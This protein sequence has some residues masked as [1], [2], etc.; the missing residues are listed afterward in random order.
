MMIKAI[1]ISRFIGS[2]GII[3]FCSCNKNNNH[4]PTS[5]NQIYATITPVSGSPLI[6]NAVGDNAIFLAGGLLPGVGLQAKNDAHAQLDFIIGDTPNPGAYPFFLTYEVNS[7]SSTAPV[8]DN[9]PS[10][11]SN[12]GSVNITAVSN[13]HIEGCFNAICKTGLQFVKHD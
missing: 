8:Y 9:N 6:I 3:L 1:C 13:H 2:L 12:P 10:Y 11:V 4:T 5:Q 7:T